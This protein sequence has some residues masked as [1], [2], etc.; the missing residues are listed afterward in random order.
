MLSANELKQME[1][2][3][4]DPNPLNRLTGDYYYN[5]RK[6]V[7]QDYTTLLARAEDIEQVNDAKRMFYTNL[8]ALEDEYNNDRKLACTLH[9]MEKNIP[10]TDII[11]TPTYTA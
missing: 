2:L 10:A 6:Q 1:I 5:R 3:K 7:R 9:L 11:H 4:K 8:A